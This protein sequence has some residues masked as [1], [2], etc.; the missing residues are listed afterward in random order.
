M[1]IGITGHQRLADASAWKWV[2]RE[3]A[4]ILRR[5]ADSLIGVSSLAVGADQI[6][7]DLVLQ[8]G[9]ALEVVIPF[10]GYAQQFR[11]GR[12]A[13]EYKRL[14]L[15]ASGV[16]TLRNGS[17]E[18][19]YMEAGMRVV[20]SSDLLVALWD[21]QP[22]SGLGG[23]AD[24]VAYAVRQKKRVVHLNPVTRTIESV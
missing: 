4:A 15:S 2:R 10:P 19:A 14:L 16:E 20:N 18:E 5:N 1:R 9:G 21:G 3:L 12:D 7:A 17:D 22:S 13:E 11:E 6:F 8:Q 23:T 24:V